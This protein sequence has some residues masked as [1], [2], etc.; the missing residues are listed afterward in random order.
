M[1]LPPQRRP[2]PKS[3]S[4]ASR[5]SAGAFSSATTLT[6]STS[7]CGKRR[8]G[9]TRRNFTRVLPKRP[10]GGSADV[11]LFDHALPPRHA[12]A[13][14]RPVGEAGVAGAIGHA[15]ER[16]VTA[17]AEVGGAR[18]ADRPAAALLA[19]F[20]QREALRA[21]DRRAIFGLLFVVERLQHPIL[22]PRDRSRA[23]RFGRLF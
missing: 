14:S 1:K 5:R 11:I 4:T 2:R 21:D 7:A 17:K 13:R 20:E 3:S 23:A 6:D 15:V 10:A 16:R 9:P 12:L 22:K 18:R 19:Q 8:S